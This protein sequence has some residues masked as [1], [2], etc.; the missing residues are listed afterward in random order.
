MEL[1]KKVYIHKSP[2][3]G[4]MTNEGDITKKGVEY[5]RKDALVKYL[6]EEKG[7]PITLNGE[8][9]H[10]DELTKSLTEYNEWKKDDFIKKACNW[11]LNN[12]KNYSTN[13]LGV[14]NLIEDFKDYMK[15]E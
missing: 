13:A 9:V 2:F 5:I 11:L 4:L 8:L 12:L 14:E 10:W 15:G 3:W 1:P 6:Y 7:Y